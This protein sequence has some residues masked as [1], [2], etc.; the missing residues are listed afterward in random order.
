MK[1]LLIAF[2]LVAAISCKTTKELQHKPTLSVSDEYELKMLLKPNSEYVT[3]L[4]QENK[5]VTSISGM[6][7]YTTRSTY[8]F[9]TKI[10][11][12]SMVGNQCNMVFSY[13]K[14]NVDFHGSF[15]TQPDPSKV[16]DLRLYGK[17][18]DGVQSIDSI[19]GGDPSI[20]SMGQDLMEHIT[21]SAQID[22]P[23]SM[24]IGEDFKI[25]ED[26]DMPSAGISSSSFTSVTTYT[27][28]EVT[29]D[30]AHLT[31]EIE[32]TGNYFVKDE[33]NIVRGSGHGMLILDINE[34]YAPSTTTV[35]DQIVTTERQGD[36]I[37]YE[38]TMSMELK[39][40]KIK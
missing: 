34:H 22:F 25:T 35:V 16:D 17:L 38:G 12:D 8:S 39:I 24:K 40:Q 31:T 1:Q 18:T 4:I 7:N 36:P 11:T 32:L 37:E 23:N 27:L 10:E 5:T 9:T 21:N 13:E 29:N 15:G 3:E 26:V 19:V 20:R 28:T 33:E 2:V 6:E 14:M 30:M